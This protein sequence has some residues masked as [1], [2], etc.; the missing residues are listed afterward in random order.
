MAIVIVTWDIPGTSAQLPAYGAKA[1]EWVK[2]V[3]SQP[4]LKEYSAHRN[5]MGT[6]PQAM[7]IQN[8][9][10]MESARAWMDSDAAQG[11]MTEMR[12]LGCSSISLQLWGASPLMPERLTTDS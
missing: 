7:T 3:M 6:T 9:A 10:N 1:A 12:A 11:I 8:F 5:P 2:I 4:G